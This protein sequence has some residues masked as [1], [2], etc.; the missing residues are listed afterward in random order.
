MNN[1][2]EA[3]QHLVDQVPDLLQP[4][5]IAIAAA[6]PYIEGE[7]AAALGVIAGINPIVAAFAAAAG[8]IICVIVIV[9][10]GSRI[11]AAITAHRAARTVSVS[12]STPNAETVVE[13]A[14]AGPPKEES[15]GRKRLRRFVVRFGVPG[16]SLL[17]PIALPTQLTAAALVA[18]GVTKS[19]VILWQVIAILAWTTLVTLAATGFLTLLTG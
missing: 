19:W 16:A 14:P 6:V 9:L 12:P 7:G 11:R 13:E 10:L 5:I 2:Y 18:S 3:F 8:N 17:G 4:L 15:K 1:P